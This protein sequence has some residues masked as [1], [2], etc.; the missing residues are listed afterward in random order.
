M[1]PA[2]FFSEA[3]QSA[4]VLKFG[5]L[6]SPTLVRR[7]F[8]KQYP[9]IPHRDV[10]HVKVFMRVL[11]RFQATNTTHHAKGTGRPTVRTEELIETVRGL[12][13]N[14]CSI[15]ISEIALQVE[16]CEETVRLIITKNLKMHCFK[17]HNVVPLSDAHKERRTD[18]CHWI[19]AQ[20]MGFP[21]LVIWSDEK[22][23]EER[24]RPNRQNE[25]YWGVVNPHVTDENRVQGGRKVMC[26]AGIIDGEIILH[27][28]PEGTKVNQHV[29]LD[30]LQTVLWPKVRASAT[31]K[32]WYFQQDGATPHTTPM[33]LEWLA[34]K[35]GDRI[36]SN[37]TDLEWP[38]RS[39]DMSP[40][41]FWFWGACLARL[42]KVRYHGLEMLMDTVTDYAAS[43]PKADVR[44]AVN[45]IL[46][47]ADCCIEHGGGSFEPRLKE[48][49]RANRDVEE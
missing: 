43:I 2:C 13:L 16:V 22:T 35:F 17:S 44:R 38:P 27:W 3:Q 36:I 41:D 42:R 21:N 28:F 12:I 19:K 23:F 47:R 25:R 24:T 48:F 32:G 40:L 4:I 10:P 7:W 1:A 29:Y 39:P 8:K 26:W 14:D 18:F 34:S 15:S 37:L 33:V 46:V 5:E 49:K 20:P 31:R 9:H 30:M 11:E 6:K 45:D